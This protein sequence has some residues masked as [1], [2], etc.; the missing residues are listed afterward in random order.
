MEQCLIMQKI[1][2][3]EQFVGKTIKK[4]YIEDGSLI[5]E[6]D[7]LTVQIYNNIFNVLIIKAR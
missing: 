3:P 4:C 2:D 5:I 1:I 6:F 7:D